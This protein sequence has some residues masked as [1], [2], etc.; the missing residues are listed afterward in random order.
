MK[1]TTIIFTIA[2]LM[3]CNNSGDRR[4]A[5]ERV[6]KNNQNQKKKQQLKNLNGKQ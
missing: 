6:Y 3:G 4:D 5:M 1:H 2:I